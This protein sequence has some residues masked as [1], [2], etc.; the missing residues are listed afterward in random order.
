MGK[1]EERTQ[2][3]AISAILAPACRNSQKGIKKLL[4]AVAANEERLQHSCANSCHQTKLLSLTPT[5]DV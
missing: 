2:L 1:G 3:A 5:L 4:L